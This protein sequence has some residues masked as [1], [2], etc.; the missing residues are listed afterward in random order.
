MKDLELNTMDRGIIKKRK[1]TDVILGLFFILC[2]ICLIYISVESYIKG[3]LKKILQTFDSNGN[4]CGI[5]KYKDYKYLYINNPKK[6]LKNTVCVKKCPKSKKEKVKCV[7]NKSIKNCNDLKIIETISFLKTICIPKEFEINKLIRQKINLGY[8]SEGIEDIKFGWMAILTCFIATIVLLALFFHLLRCCAACLFWIFI[9]GTI[10]GLG[11]AGYYCF[12]RSRSKNNEGE[13]D[14]TLFYYSILFWILSAFFCIVSFCYCRKISIALKMIKSSSVFVS[15]KK[16]VLL[17]PFL[18]T[19]FIL[20][21]IVYWTFTFLYLLS[22]GDLQYEN[23]DLFGKIKRDLK[24]NI[25]LIFMV[26]FGI[27][28]LFYSLSSNILTIS[29][30]TTSWY[31]DVRREGVSFYKAFF[32][33]NF[34][35]LGSTAFGSFILV[36]VWPIQLVLKFLYILIKNTKKD[37]CCFSCFNCFQICYENTLLFINRHSYIEIGIRNF[38][39]CHAIK[40]NVHLFTG[41]Y[42]NLGSLEGIAGYFL[43]MGSLLISTIVTI[44]GCYLLNLTEK[45]Y[46]GEFNTILPLILIALISF[47]ITLFFNYVYSV[48][49]DTLLHCFMFED[50]SFGNIQGNCTDDL[51]RIINQ[52][53]SKQDNKM[54]S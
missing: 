12:D 38:N 36:F 50:E 1:F 39:F 48:S 37:N 7:V 8:I 28:N 2:S 11:F 24:T 40:K 35:H 49:S 43:F 15:E 54:I 4:K 25:F 42:K 21:F 33:S 32:W 13:T 52:M 19:L 18:H 9:Y 27:W 47:F 14:L 29:L 6:N 31:F 53:D 23:G 51:R 26:F 5:K 22:I 34:Y 3:D 44:L 20:L 41:L 46:E 10:I 16:S 17:V 30:I 45:I